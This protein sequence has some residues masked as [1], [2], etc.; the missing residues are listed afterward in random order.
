MLQIKEMLIPLRERN[1]VDKETCNSIFANV[2]AILAASQRFLQAVASRAATL[3]ASRRS[4]IPAGGP[5]FLP[6]NTP[7]TTTPQSA[8]PVRSTTVEQIANT[9]VHS[10]AALLDALDTLDVDALYTPYIENFNNAVGALERATSQHA[11]VRAIATRVGAADLLIEPVQ[12]LARYTMMLRALH[13]SCAQQHLNQQLDA[14]AN[15][16]CD[17]INSGD[18]ARLAR[19]LEHVESVARRVDDSLR[20]AGTLIEMA[21]TG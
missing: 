17:I 19:A 2:E 14:D 13:T 7:A 6:R 10:L 16:E 5:R 1:L 8:R 18:L 3:T 12:R 21:R 4:P 15:G 9:Q 11:A 20:R